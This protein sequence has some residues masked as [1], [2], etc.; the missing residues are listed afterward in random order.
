[1]QIRTGKGTRLT[2]LEVPG[3]L[4]ITLE[5]LKE[6]EGNDLRTF[7]RER[8]AGEWR[9]RDVEMKEGKRIFHW[10]R[11]GTQDQVASPNSRSILELRCI[12]G[13]RHFTI[14]CRVEAPVP[15][16]LNAFLNF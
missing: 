9:L 1:M 3:N 7:R 10:P 13:S 15:Q 14:N 2:V 5:V 4:F 6:Q 11:P 8:K 12:P 16:E